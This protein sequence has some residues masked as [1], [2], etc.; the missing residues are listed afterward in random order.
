MS[1]IAG[2]SLVDFIKAN[3]DVAEL[4]KAHRCTRRRKGAQMDLFA[5]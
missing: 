4:V 1:A 5:A 3:P 2:V